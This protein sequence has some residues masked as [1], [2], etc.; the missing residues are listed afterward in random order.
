M[1]LCY[2]PDRRGMRAV[3][4]LVRWN[5]AYIQS[6]K[7]HTN[8]HMTVIAKTIATCSK[9]FDAINIVLYVQN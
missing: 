8:A 9:F 2:G 4:C 5:V 7:I 6:F 1:R 3:A